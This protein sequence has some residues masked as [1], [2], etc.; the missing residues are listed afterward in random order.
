[1][2]AQLQKELKISDK[3]KGRDKFV[4]EMIWKERDLLFAFNK[5]L[6]DFTQFI[7]NL[8]NEGIVTKEEI[9]RVKDYVY[10]I[11]R[12]T[13]ILIDVNKKQVVGFQKTVVV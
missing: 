10:Y 4:R 13:R 3:D 5:V 9:K 2:N 6:I 1:M 7:N 8:P 11:M 12:I